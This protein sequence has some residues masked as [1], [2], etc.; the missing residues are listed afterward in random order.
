MITINL[1]FESQSSEGSSQINSNVQDC[2]DEL[3]SLN[4]L[5]VESVSETDKSQRGDIV[6]GITEIVIKGIELGFFAGVYTVLKDLYDRKKNTDV[7][8]KFKN[9][10]SVSIKG[11]SQEEA[12]KIIEENSN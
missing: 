5:T 2:I 6:N 11:L 12:L 8:I 4:G 7:T 1:V 10:N 9:G 3:Y